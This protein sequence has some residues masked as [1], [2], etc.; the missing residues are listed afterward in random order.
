MSEVAIL[1]MSDI[2]YGKKTSTFGPAACKAQ[3]DRISNRLHVIQHSMKGRKVEKLIIAMLGDFNDGSD[4]YPTQDHHQEITNPIQQAEELGTYL[5]DW[6]HT[7][8]DIWKRVEIQAVCGNHGRIGKRIHEA[9][10]WDLL[11]YKHLE[12]S[13]KG[14]PISYDQSDIGIQMFDVYKHRFLL[15]HGHKIGFGGGSPFS[16]IR[17]RL[18]GWLTTRQVGHFDV[19]M[20]GHFHLTSHFHVNRLKV[21]L[22]GTPVTSDSW[23]LANGWENNNEWWLFGVSEAHPI[24]WQYAVNLL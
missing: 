14:I 3:L 20:M 24:T 15:Y 19:A 9:A 13:L 7:Q 8:R 6:V 2:H 21:L 22:S 1:T 23:G 18:N 11:V 10:N 12:K 4:I 17:Q 5:T 16:S